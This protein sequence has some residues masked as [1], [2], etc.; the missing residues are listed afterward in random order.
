MR[1]AVL[2]VGLLLA[3]HGIAQEAAPVTDT[4]LKA[5]YCLGVVTVQ[6]EIHAAELDQLKARVARGRTKD[7]MQG[8]E[9]EI[10]EDVHKTL[11]ERRDRMRDYLVSKGFLGRRN[12][13]E[14]QIALLR[15]PADDKAC[16]VENNDPIIGSCKRRCG[17]KTTEDAERCNTRCA[18]EACMRTARC[19]QQFLPF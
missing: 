9:L 7:V 6:I 4:E 14:I 19:L 11:I 1:F 15:G 17:I 2:L 18:S 5:A 12:I 13:R 16:A 8:I 3:T 10:E